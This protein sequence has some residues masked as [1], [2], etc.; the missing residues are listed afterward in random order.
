MYHFKKGIL[1]IYATIVFFAGFC[2][3]LNAF[4]IRHTAPNLHNNKRESFEL[5]KDGAI[6][7]SIE[8]P[9][10]YTK[11]ELDA[12]KTLS[13]Y[14]RAIARTGNVQISN[15][16]SELTFPNKIKISRIEN[17]VIPTPK[18]P[19][20]D[21]ARKS[22]VVIHKNLIE[23]KYS[24]E[25]RNAVGVLLKHLG[26]KFLAPT[27][28]GTEYP[29]KKRDVKIP[30]QTLVFNPPLMS[31]S[32]YPVVTQEE[33]E[34]FT[35]NGTDSFFRHFNHN[36][37]NIFDEKAL[38]GNPQFAPILKKYDRAFRANVNF[39]HLDAPL[40]AAI[41]AY[42]YFLK[43]PNEKFYSLGLDDS[44]VHDIRT[45]KNPYPNDIGREFPNYSNSFFEFA[46]KTAKL[47]EKVEPEKFV[48][49]LSYFTTEMPPDFQINENIVPVFTTDKSCYATSNYK[50]TDFALMQ[51]WKDSGA[52]LCA[53]WSYFY[54]E[55]Y[56]TPRNI[57]L[58]EA[59]AVKKMIEIG[60][61]SYFA[62]LGTVWAYDAPKVN[63]I[64]SILNGSKENPLN[65]L[66]RFYFDYYKES[67]SPMSEFF[68]LSRRE[69]ENAN[70]SGNWLVYYT[71]LNEGEIF[72]QEIL[73]KMEEALSTAEFCAKSQIVK[74]RVNE[75][76]L[77]FEKTK[78]FC[79]FYNA[80]KQLLENKNSDLSTL[81]NDFKNAKSSLENLK[82][83][84]D[85]AHENSKF[86]Q[87]RVL[88]IYNFDYSNSTRILE[89]FSI[90][91]SQNEKS[92]SD[93][94]TLQ[95]IEDFTNTKVAIESNKNQKTLIRLNFASKF[96][97]P[98][99][100]NFVQIPDTIFARH[101]P[102][103]TSQ[104]GIVKDDKNAGVLRAK[105]VLSSKIVRTVEVEENDL[106]LAEFDVEYRLSK[107]ANAYLDIVFFDENFKKISTARQVLFPTT[108]LKN[109]NVK[110]LAR[111]PKCAKYASISNTNIY[112]NNDSLVDIKEMSLK[113]ITENK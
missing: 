35:L 74:E 47:L 1:L 18:N 110:I 80:Q 22:L 56:F 49:T 29:I 87:H 46:N 57:E 24:Q 86:P 60:F 103:K 83:L 108:P 91:K 102:S 101:T 6:F 38:K 53:M 104:F 58:Y 42:K 9:K 69:W 55:P 44:T 72:T 10:S 96:F 40:F 26:Y 8:L 78:A 25:P 106:L 88:Y 43:N 97:N 70:K 105:N 109:E 89:N 41:K 23:L 71:K 27:E 90:N 11:N 73:E 94:L 65:I 15:D 37:Q 107:S 5:I 61:T 85:F 48:P 17:P 19:E 77:R 66:Y 62:E 28:L 113:K 67:A 63:L 4:Q 45:K 2:G 81:K 51:K 112:L 33:R 82:K 52:K 79:N 111:T 16:A 31:I 76:R 32:F 84:D 21:G 12:A 3:T 68:K 99:D 59:Q 64:L 14:L 30:T 20:T 34:F 13:K 36:M 50:E 92:F 7:V 93:I 95:E 75:V 100:E 98:K 39:T 54:G